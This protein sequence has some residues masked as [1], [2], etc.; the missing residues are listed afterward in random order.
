MLND[1]LKFICK[2]VYLKVNNKT[3]IFTKGIK[4]DIIKLPIAHK[5]GNY[6]IDV[7]K[8]KK[9]IEN[10]QI[11]F[12]YCSEKGNISELSNPNGSIDNI[13]GILSENKKILG[14]MP[15]PERFTNINYKDLIM[16]QILEYM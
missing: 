6:T 12:S 1:S 15:H 14:M 3:S 7:I 16:K 11:A 13:A 5:M 2:E 8:R 9:L 4:S 10:S